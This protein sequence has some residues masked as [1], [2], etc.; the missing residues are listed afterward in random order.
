MEWIS[1]EDRLPINCDKDL[2]GKNYTDME[3]IVCLDGVVCVDHFMAGNTV[4]FWCRFFQHNV[5]HWMPLPSPPE[6]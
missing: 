6:D 2:D 1:V 5:T 3:V 4:G